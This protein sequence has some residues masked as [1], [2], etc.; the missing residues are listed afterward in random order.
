MLVTLFISVFLL[1]LVWQTAQQEA[2]HSVSI[3]VSQSPLSAPFYVA[4]AIDAFEG[5]CVDV[6]Y[7]EVIGGQRAFAKVM[8]GESDF[9]TSSDSVIAYNSLTKKN[10]VTHAMF[11]QSDNDVKLIS[12]SVAQN[13]ALSDLKG[14]KIGVTKGSASE[15]F[16]SMLLAIEGL[17]IED[18]ELYH[19]KPEQLVDGIVKKEVD[20]IVPWEPFA[21]NTV[22]LLG[23][24]IKVHDTKN[25]NTLS[26]TLISKQADNLLLEKA[27]CLLQ[28]LS[29][30]IEYIAL[31]PEASKKI[32]MEELN[33]GNSF[34][35]WV[36]RDYIFKLGLNQALLLSIQSQAQWSA[37]MLN[38]EVDDLPNVERFVDARAL[39]HVDPGAVNIPR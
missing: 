20:A 35:N 17:T 15:Y 30:A 39:L 4:K 18:V 37:L 33:L 28:G 1:Y 34:I 21:F 10:F 14:Q 8:N 22:K 24:Q 3:A 13:N 23:E 38:N 29:T 36:W 19:Y 6:E 31:H 26:F 16:L 27:Q 5:T 32:V 12:R 2:K 7:H 9:G 11:V 25:I